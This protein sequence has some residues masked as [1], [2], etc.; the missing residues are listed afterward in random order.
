MLSK[1]IGKH[2]FSLLKGEITTDSYKESIK[3]LTIGFDV[4]T[5][6]IPSRLVAGENHIWFALE[7]SLNAFEQKTAFTKKPELEFIVRLVADKQLNKA[8]EK[9]EFKKNEPLI[10]VIGSADEKAINK[11]K[12]TLN[13]KEKDFQLGLNKEELVKYFGI[14]KREIES[15]ADVKNPLEELI[16]ER[17][18]FVS[19]EK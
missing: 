15:L 16:I 9:A 4:F 2:G 13:F 8:L 5:Q 17:C 19:L 12:E 14:E 11:I 3:K 18:A 1:T 6:I 7:Q 10:L